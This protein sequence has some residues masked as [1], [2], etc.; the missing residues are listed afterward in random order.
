MKYLELSLIKYKRMLLNNVSSFTI[1]PTEPIQLILGTN[2][3]GKS[4]LLHELTPLPATMSD[5]STGGSKYIKIEHEGVIYDLTSTFEGIQK[6]NFKKNNIELNTGGTLSVQK[7]LVKQMFGIT[8]EIHQ[9]LSTQNGLCDMTPSVRRYWFTKLSDTNYDYAIFVY[10][11]LKEKSRDISG[12]IKLAKNKLVTQTSKLVSEQEQNDI[13][14][15]VEQLHEILQ[16]LIEYRKP[17]DY[18]KIDL[19]NKA[20]EIEKQITILFSGLMK[21]KKSHK[22]SGVSLESVQTRLV[23]IENLSQVEKLLIDHYFAEHTKLEESIS[24]LKETGGEGSF[25]FKQK[26]DKLL[27]TNGK[28]RNS[29]KLNIEIEDACNSQ[30]A[31][32]SVYDTLV[33]VFSSLPKNIDK[34]FSRASLEQVTSKNLLLKAELSK[35]E[36]L[37]NK[38]TVNKD[39]QE[40]Q[41]THDVLTCPKCTYSWAKGFDENYYNQTV[42]LLENIQSEIDEITS[43][44]QETIVQ[45]EEIINYSD[46]YKQFSTCTNSLPILKPLWDYLLTTDSITTQP[47]ILLTILEKFKYDLQIDVEIQTVEKDIIR[48]KELLKLSEQVGKSDIIKL[49]QE[50]ETIDNKISNSTLKIQNLLNERKQLSLYKRDMED[51]IQLSDS[52]SLLGIQFVQCYEETIESFRRDVVI[53]SIKSIQ[54]ILSNKQTQ[55][56]EMQQQLSVIESIKQQLSDFEADDIAYKALLKEL[57]PIDG[58]IAEGLLGFISSFIKQ[59]NS[60]IKKIWNYP[61]EIVSC[62]LSQDGQIELDYKFPLIVQNQDKPVDD[63]NEG[64]SAMKEVIDLAFKLTAMKYLNLEESP[65]Y[66]DEFSAS[67]DAAHRVSSIEAIK[68]LMDQ[69]SFTQ[70]FMVSH[71][72]NSYGALT[73]AQI[74]VLC[75][76]NIVI[77]TGSIFNEHVTQS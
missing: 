12:A 59:M 47:N 20:I 17:Q 24:A 54:L 67:F 40:H 77:P 57:S 68:S 42:L 73:N 76:N 53:D 61:L 32:N 70:M 21:K 74:C 5:Y 36:S 31:F 8:N 38:A 22:L 18:K 10:N 41:K 44:I 65:I 60:F 63:I 51:I 28:K 45:K 11:K 55:L 23:E 34:Q 6:H 1:K 27:E 14:K 33:N 16:H 62:G 29:K 26:I 69:R 66:L 35:L 75:S 50:L 72:E 19:E 3:S 4:S 2:G 30:L 9:L 7:E 13:Q 46:I 49:I 39:Q 48:T 43:K 25:E 15:E 37:L 58:L 71:Y 56:S 52:I 64:S